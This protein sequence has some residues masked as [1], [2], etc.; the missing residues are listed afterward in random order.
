[1][2]NGQPIVVDGNAISLQYDAMFA[3]DDIVELVVSVGIR[4]T[5]RGLPLARRERNGNAFGRLAI[6]HNTA[7]HLP[8]LG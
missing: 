4:H 7:S 6:D 3:N 5:T 2:F 8:N 1:M